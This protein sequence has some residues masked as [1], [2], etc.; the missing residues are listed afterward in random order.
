MTALSCRLSALSAA[1][2]LVAVSA[3]AQIPSTGDD[4]PGMAAFDQLAK[5]LMQKYHIPG[6]AI[7]VVKDGKLIFA[8]GYGY[9]NREKRELVQ[10]DS[11]FRI[12]SVTKPLT[13][14][15][16]LKLVEQGKL[17]L[18]DK[19]FAILPDIQPLPNA[20]VDPRTANITV[21]ELLQHSGGWNRDTSFDP[22]FM[23]VQIAQAN[24]VP[25]PANPRQIARYM[26]GQPLQFDPGTQYN[27]SNF[28]YSLLGRIIQHVT[29]TSYESWVRANILAPAGVACMAI[30]HT[31]QSQPLPHEVKYYD[32]PGAPLVDSVFGGG[33]KVPDPDG[34][35]YI[36]AM[37]SHGAWVA[38]TI[39]Y[40][41]FVT[42][43]DGGRIISPASIKT[44]LA[45]PS[46]PS[47]QG[48]DSW[49]GMGWMVRPSG[50]SANWWHNGSLAGTTTLV[51]RT[52][53]GLAWA[54]FFNS[55]QK[56][57]DLGGDLDSG[58]WDA[59]SK[60]QLPNVDL[61]PRFSCYNAR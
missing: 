43:L 14:A 35:F 44:M 16:I 53:D 36:E 15:A 22:M 26:R 18:D 1:L 19:V 5:S 31:R 17:H 46:I 55:R 49:Y 2:L 60:S 21:R 61:F 40:L 54:A 6:G 56:S 32:Y 11:A 58:L 27:Y 51:V 29:R 39:D 12:A 59:L 37:D 41:R 28:G 30:G 23:P 38:S 24:G 45:R 7:A 3:L 52:S 13:S 47:W 4:P 20:H 34:G 42:A 8:R 25:P 10:P 9:A 50:N 48:K 33:A 57:G